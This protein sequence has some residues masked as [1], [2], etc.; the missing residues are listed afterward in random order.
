MHKD[1][2]RW[3]KKKKIVDNIELK[4]SFFYHEREI[5]W[6]AIGLNIGVEADGKNE[7][8]ERPI[9]IIKKFNKHM[10]WGIP[11]TSHEKNGKFYFKVA[12]PEGVSWG[13]LTQLKVF[14]TKR[15]LRKITTV[16]KE[17]VLL[18]KHLLSELLLE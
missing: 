11:L 18:I 7:Y 14:S 15:L 6:S 9:L 2:N 13:M 17:D 16:S 10:F 12:Y 3:N 8:F 5:W 1:F 4:S